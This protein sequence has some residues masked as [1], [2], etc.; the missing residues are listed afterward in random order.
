[1]VLLVVIAWY[2]I[3]FI[4]KISIENSILVKFSH[5]AVCKAPQQASMKLK[6]NAQFVEDVKERD[7]STAGTGAFKTESLVLLENCIQGESVYAKVPLLPHHRRKRGVG[8][9]TRTVLIIAY[10]LENSV[11]SLREPK[12]ENIFSVSIPAEPVLTH[13]FTRNLKGPVIQSCGSVCI[14]IL[15]LLA[16]IYR[17]EWLYGSKGFAFII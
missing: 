7:K 11:L 13:G 14:R 12:I 5:D 17:F 16:L 4:I 6:A 2:F 3:G 10:H 8:I 15:F 1:V 9:T